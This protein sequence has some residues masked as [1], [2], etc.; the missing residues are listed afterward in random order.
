M[1]CELVIFD[2]D[3][4][5]IDS[6]PLSVQADVECL[7]EYGLAVAAEDIIERYTGISLAGMLADLEARHGCR[8]PGFAER[9]QK[10]LRH[11]I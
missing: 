1:G 10:R 8:F 4:V 2:C 11:L 6:E 9:N 3:G 7:A 5:L